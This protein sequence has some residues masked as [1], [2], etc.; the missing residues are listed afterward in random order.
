ME[1][2]FLVGSE[3]I[4]GGTYVIF[5]H[6]IRMNRKKDIN[7]TLITEHK[8]NPQLD[9]QWHPEAK[10]LTWRTY[11]ECLSS[12][13]DV[14]I[15]TWWR[16]VYEMHRINA[17]QYCYFVQS[18]ESKFYPEDDVELRQL[19]DSTYMFGLS[20]IT[21]A[22]WIKNFLQE[23]YL[24]DVKLVR[25]GIRKDIYYSKSSKKDE[26]FRVLVEGPLGVPFKNTEKALALARN[27]QADEVW[28]LTSSRCNSH[29]MADKVFSK[30]PMHETPRIYE[31]CDVLV[32]LS[33]VEGM[34]GP[35][36]EIFHCGGT[37]IVYK[38]TGCDE[39]MINGYN[40][41]I[42]EKDDEEQVVSLL[43]NLVVNKE[44]LAR[45]K[46]NASITSSKWHDWQSASEEFLLALQQICKAPSFCQKKLGRNITF[47]F[48]WYEI[49]VNL[50]PHSAR[51]K[52]ITR[53][54]ER[55]KKNAFMMRVI[56]KFR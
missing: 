46:A 10:E 7:V 26:K 44:E 53:I 55:I 12:E 54:K 35:P 47:F 15:A 20:I 34:F 33:Y 25:N 40:S 9:L 8:V 24:L 51:E 28:L 43:N 41:Y 17:K 48:K 11:S 4:S 36:L 42:V 14:L 19:V 30:V 31:Q 39:Y 32:K 13:F 29:E 18:I 49:A 3:K 5:E 45:L 38:V 6:A 37:A 2:A 50:R 21:E 56:N 1:I 22:T 52:I 27:S 23:N 16:T